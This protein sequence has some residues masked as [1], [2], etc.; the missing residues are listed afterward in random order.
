VA[1]YLYIFDR[2]LRVDP[3]CPLRHDPCCAGSAPLGVFGFAWQQHQNQ[4]CLLTAGDH[5]PMG[6]RRIGVAEQH[7]IDHGLIRPSRRETE[8]GPAPEGL[9]GKVDQ[10]LEDIIGNE[11]E[12]RVAHEDRGGDRNAGWRVFRGQRLIAMQQ[13][14]NQH[15]RPFS[16]A[17]AQP[18]RASSTLDPRA[19][20]GQ[21]PAKAMPP[22]KI[23]A[24]PMALNTTSTTAV[25]G[26]AS[27]VATASRTGL[28]T[29]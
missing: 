1:H 20:S 26:S 24:L 7:E 28:M 19:T 23:A 12:W 16:V 25:S 10:P 11:W 29:R 4:S 17:P 15:K 8:H 27:A 21:Y 13:V 2:A 22:M 18:T 6:L 3:S 9:V 14:A 5:E